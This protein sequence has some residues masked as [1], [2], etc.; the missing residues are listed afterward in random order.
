MEFPES[1]ELSLGASVSSGS[2]SGVIVGLNQAV[3]DEE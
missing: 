3:K 1:V 2:A